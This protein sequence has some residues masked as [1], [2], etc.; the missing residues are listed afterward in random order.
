MLPLYNFQNPE[1]VLIINK[2]VGPVLF[3]YKIDDRKRNFEFINN[4]YTGF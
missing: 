4:K 3:H 1:K 2:T